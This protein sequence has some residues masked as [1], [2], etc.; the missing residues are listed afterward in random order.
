MQHQKCLN[1]Q[2]DITIAG[3]SDGEI[4]FSWIEWDEDDLSRR[5]NMYCFKNCSV[6]QN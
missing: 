1:E 2:Q 5:G 3:E 6:N 4:S